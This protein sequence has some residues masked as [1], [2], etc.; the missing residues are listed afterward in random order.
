MSKLHEPLV[1]R[2][3]HLLCIHGF[4]GMGYSEQFID[5][6]STIVEQMKDDSPRK[7]RVIQGLDS[8]CASCPHQGPGICQASDDSERHVLGL[9]ENV[10]KHLNL[11]PGA[12][13]DK[14]E[15]IKRTRERVRPEDLD[16]LCR[17]C[18]WLSYGVCKEGI[19]ALRSSPLNTSP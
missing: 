3:H 10:L 17:G 1:L 15:L 5:K 16:H 4:R 6:M 14:H 9:D 12:I 2:A 18:S 8:A 7:V 11:I 13:Y 19:A